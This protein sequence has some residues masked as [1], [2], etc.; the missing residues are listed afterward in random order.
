MP[1]I[2]VVFPAAGRKAKTVAQVLV[3]TLV[4]H[5]RDRVNW[6][7]YNCDPRIR[8]AEI[9]FEHKSLPFF[10]CQTPANRHRFKKPIG[11]SGRIYGE[12]P[13]LH[14]SRPVSAKYTVRGLDSSG[15]VR[16]EVDPE[17]IVD[18]P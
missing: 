13:N 17:I 10:P 4:A 14:K 11:G 1:E 7:F 5:E 18:E 15:K 6:I 3:P 2:Q 16:S 12:V 8:Y 9:H